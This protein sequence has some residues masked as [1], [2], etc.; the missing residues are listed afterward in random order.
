MMG[1]TGWGM[2]SATVVLVG[3]VALVAAIIVW[4]MLGN[5]QPTSSAD[6]TAKDML[7]RRLAQ[8]EISTEDYEKLLQ[9]LDVS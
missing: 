4:Q 3:L 9:Q 8:G 6:D 5:T 1:A 2:L 7:K